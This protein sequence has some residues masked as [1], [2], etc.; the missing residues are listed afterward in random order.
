MTRMEQIKTDKIKTDYKIRIYPLHQC[1]PCSKTGN[2]SF[3]IQPGFF[4]ISPLLYNTITTM[5]NPRNAI[6]KVR[7][8]FL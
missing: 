3:Y 6:P 2:E 5:I 7:V 4:V 1:H 8:S